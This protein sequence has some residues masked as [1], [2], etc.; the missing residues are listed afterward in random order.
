MK[1]AAVQ[2]IKKVSA[3][4]SRHSPIVWSVRQ[5]R[6]RIAITFD[7]GPTEITPQV[8]ECLARHG[9]KATFFVLARQVIQQPDVLRQI[10]VNGHEVG[11]HGYDH[12]LR[13]YYRQIR[14]CEDVLAEYGA[15]PFIVRTPGCVVRPVLAMRLWLRGY[16]TAMYSFDAHDSMRLEGKWKGPTPD[17]SSIKGGDIVLM[18]DDNSLCV[19][20]LPSLL[21]SVKENKLQTVTVSELIGLKSWVRS[22]LRCAPPSRGI[23]IKLHVCVDHRLQSETR[24]NRLRS[25]KLGTLKST[26][27]ENVDLGSS[28]RLTNE[29]CGIRGRSHLH[30]FVDGA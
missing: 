21:Q 19:H 13:D 23:P 20:E 16:P 18:H 29:K 2:L 3:R 24:A 22:G 28:I 6:R 30:S 8:L 10:L 11:M 15:A 25:Q 14:Q 9:A 26:G 17:Y 7:D 4:F 5:H 1:Q 27:F 12:S